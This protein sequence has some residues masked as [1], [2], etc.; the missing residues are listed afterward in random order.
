[1]LQNFQEIRPALTLR[2]TSNPLFNGQRYLTRPKMRDTGEP[3]A[4]R[5]RVLDRRWKPVASRHT[6]RLIQLTHGRARFSRDCVGDDTQ[7]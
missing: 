3:H 4:V 1:M 7:C 2:V 6:A 5:L